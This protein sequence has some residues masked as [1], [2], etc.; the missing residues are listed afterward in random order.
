MVFKDYLKQIRIS[1]R[2]R[3][4]LKKRAKREGIS[5]AKLLDI[6]IEYWQANDDG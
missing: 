5:M 4:F 6:I 3:E 1:E 2:R